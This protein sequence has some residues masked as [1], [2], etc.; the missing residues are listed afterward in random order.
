[1]TD[2]DEIYAFAIDLGRK[3]GQTLLHNVEKRISGAVQEVE[4][5]DSAVD[6]VTQTDEGRAI[7]TSI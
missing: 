3:A 5:K 4:E 6:I 7:C 2:L 1:M